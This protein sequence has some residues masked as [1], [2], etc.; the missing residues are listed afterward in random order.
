MREETGPLKSRCFTAI[1]CQNKDAVWEFFQIPYLEGRR[2]PKLTYLQ[3]IGCIK[4]WEKWGKSAE[5]FSGKGRVWD[6]DT[7]RIIVIIITIIKK[8]NCT[9]KI[10]L[11]IFEV[12]QYCTGTSLLL[13]GIT[14]YWRV[15]SLTVSFSPTHTHTSSL[16]LCR[17]YAGSPIFQ[18]C[19]AWELQERQDGAHCWEFLQI[20]N[21]KSYSLYCKLSSYI[22]QGPECAN[23]S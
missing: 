20:Y 9:K 1:A 19:I 22:C 6:K 2:Y 21:F 14:L 8:K 18:G 13:T 15:P 11:F 23:K 16:L 5:L 7:V 17:W 10:F 3:C 4:D 12:S